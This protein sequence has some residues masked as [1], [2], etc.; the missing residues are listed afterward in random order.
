MASLTEV[1]QRLQASCYRRMWI[2]IKGWTDNKVAVLLLFVSHGKHRLSISAI[3][4]PK[5][6]EGEDPGVLGF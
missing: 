1:V 2:T 5:V 3:A 4:S 6:E